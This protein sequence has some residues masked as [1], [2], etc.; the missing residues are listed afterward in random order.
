VTRISRAIRPV[1]VDGV[2]QV[3]YYHFGVGS[4]GGIASKVIGGK[5]AF[6]ILSSGLNSI[7]ASPVIPA[8]PSIKLISKRSRLGGR[9]SRRERTRS[10]LVSRE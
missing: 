4:N 6:T 9:R 2:P 1:S 5:I 3:V 7:V 10:I 8:V